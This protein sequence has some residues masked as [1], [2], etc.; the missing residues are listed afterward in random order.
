MCCV[1]LPISLPQTSGTHVGWDLNHFL[2]IKVKDVRK[3]GKLQG[4]RLQAFGKSKVMH[5]LDTNEY[6]NVWINVRYIILNYQWLSNVED[7]T[8]GT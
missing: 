6:H 7:M 8:H 1:L 4:N 5:N 2:F 3:Y